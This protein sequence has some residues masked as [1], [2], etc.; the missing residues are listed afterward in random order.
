MPKVVISS[1]NGFRISLFTTFKINKTENFLQ[2]SNGFWFECKI[3]GRRLVAV[4]REHRGK[5]N[6]CGTNSGSHYI[7]E[8]EIE[9]KILRK[10][11]GA[12]CQV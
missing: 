6:P 8:E 2:G 5:A 4:S 10:E 11:I 7:R 3:E 12:N 1:Y 9:H